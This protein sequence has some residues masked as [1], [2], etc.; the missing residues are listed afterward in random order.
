MVTHLAKCSECNAVFGFYSEVDEPQPRRSFDNPPRGIS[1]KPS[2]DG[3]LIERRWLGPALTNLVLFFVF[4]N[5]FI[6]VWVSMGLK[7]GYYDMAT[8]AIFPALIGVGGAYALLCHIVNKTRITISARELRIK[9]GP[10]P[11][12]GNKTLPSHAIDQVFVQRKVF[13]S[14]QGRKTRFFLRYLDTQGKEGKL[15]SGLEEPA[16]ALFLEQE[17]EDT[18]GIRDRKV[19]G[20]YR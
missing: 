20:S 11:W 15:L 19:P 7:Q 6:A 9:H 16:P 12:L 17:I 10:L 8:F 5:G 3:L 14:K 18:L 1:V 13:R 4:W 2:A